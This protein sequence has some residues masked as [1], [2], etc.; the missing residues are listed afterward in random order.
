MNKIGEVHP[1]ITQIEVSTG[2]GSDRVLWQD[3]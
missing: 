1:Q 3:D 2:S